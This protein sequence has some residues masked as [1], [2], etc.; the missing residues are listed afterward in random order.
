MFL[1]HKKDVGRVTLWGIHDGTSWRNNFTV[2]GRTDYPLLFD[3]QGQP[4]AAF[5]AVQKAAQAAK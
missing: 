2:Q 5:F 3:R 1:R 4:K